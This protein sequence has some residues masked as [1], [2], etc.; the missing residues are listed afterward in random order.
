MHIKRRNMILR[1]D[2]GERKTSVRSEKGNEQGTK[3]DEMLV[4]SKEKLIKRRGSRTGG[5]RSRANMKKK[6][7]RQS[8]QDSNVT[9]ERN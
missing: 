4:A 7:R 3:E 1:C 6:Y 5:K 8:F 9:D 2:R